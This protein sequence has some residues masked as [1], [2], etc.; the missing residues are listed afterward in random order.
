MNRTFERLTL[1]TSNWVYEMVR[2]VK[3]HGRHGP[4]YL[5]NGPGLDMI[6]QN[7]HTLCPIIKKLGG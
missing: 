7:S 3:K 2:L 5:R 4:K 1:S 6:G